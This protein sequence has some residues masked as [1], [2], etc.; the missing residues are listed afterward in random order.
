MHHKRVAH[1]R[2][3]FR[4]TLVQR[5]EKHWP[6][7]LDDRPRLRIADHADNLVIPMS[8][9]HMLPN[10]IPT[11]KHCF[12]KRLVHYGKTRTIRTVVTKVASCQYWDPKRSEV[13]SRRHV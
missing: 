10:R 9:M 3:I 5:P 6:R 7:I 11:R 4:N 8:A 1:P 12:C 13:S 2:W